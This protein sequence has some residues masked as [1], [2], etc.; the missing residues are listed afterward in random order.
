MKSLLIALAGLTVF[1]SLNAAPLIRCALKEKTPS[2]P[3]VI[4]IELNAKQAFGHTLNCVYG[5][6]LG[7]VEPCAPTG[8][9]GLS[10]PTGS[11]PLV[12][13][14]MR[15]QETMNHV[16]NLTESAIST[17]SI[18]FSGA[19]VGHEGTRSSEWTF[20]VDRITGEA[21]WGTNK[22]SNGL[23]G[24]IVN[25]NCRAVSQKF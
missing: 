9:F 18:A 23:W 20:V 24:R 1:S 4:D 15:W 16:G 13:V 6:D 10:A 7:D 8:G 5:A 17:T 12:G 14:V 11:A 3:S 19:Y 21:A 22:D 25:Y 2:A